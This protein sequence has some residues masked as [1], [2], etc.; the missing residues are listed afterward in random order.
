MTIREYIVS[1]FQ[2]FGISLSEADFVDVSMSVNLDERIS[3]ENRLD[4][5]RAVAISVIPQ[6]LLR[7]KSISENGFT[8][9][10]DNDAL[11]KY[12]AW[13]CDTLEIDNMLN[14]SVVRDITNMW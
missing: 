7:A 4:A 14:R 8:I 10:W 5:L 6:L 12:Y 13:L 1:K 2:S 11:L 3:D 9:S